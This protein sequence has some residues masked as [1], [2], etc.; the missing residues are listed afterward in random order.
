MARTTI[1]VDD[2]DLMQLFRGLNQL[3]ADL[4]QT[5]NGRLRDAATRCSQ[6]LA[7]DLIQVAASRG[8]QTAL[9]AQ[10]IRPRRDR[11][12]KVALGGAKRVGTSRKGTKRAHVGELLW[13]SEK[14]GRHFPGA[15][16]WI[17]PTVTAFAET[18]AYREY[19]DATTGILHE[20][21]LI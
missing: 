14:G 3:D 9:Q 8:P 12:P 1:N 18:T 11:V 5:T 16:P 4:R 6:L 15:G 21:G 20:V 10:A 2:R 13:G 19:L 7:Q 17:A